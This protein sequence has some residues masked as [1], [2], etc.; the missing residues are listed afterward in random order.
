MEI[1]SKV[2]L[3]IRIKYTEQILINSALKKFR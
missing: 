1:V 2:D 3:D